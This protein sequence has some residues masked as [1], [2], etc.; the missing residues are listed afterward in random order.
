MAKTAK[1]TTKGEKEVE[2]ED[3]RRES[4]EKVRQRIKQAKKGP[5][6][7]LRTGVLSR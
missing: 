4:C 5:P 2:A 3:C 7:V 6:E 1:K